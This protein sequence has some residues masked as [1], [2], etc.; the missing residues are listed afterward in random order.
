MIIFIDLDGTLTHT[1]DVKY[2]EL[3]DGLRDFNVSEIP[4]FQGSIDFISKLK[5]EGHRVIILS[6]SH[7]K[8]VRPIVEYYFKVEYLYLADKPN[9]AKTLSFIQS[10]IHLNNL[11]QTNKED[12]III[13][14]SVLDIQLGRKLK[15][16][17]SYLQ[18]YKEG[19]FSE[20]DGVGDY[21]SIIKY[22]PTFITKSYQELLSIVSN[23][24]GN[25]LSL[26]A[27]SIGVSTCKSVK[28]WDYKDREHQ[29]IVAFRC[30]ARQENGSCDKFSRADLYYQIDNP[31]RREE[32]LKILATGVENYLQG[33]LQINS[34]KWDYFTYVSDKSSTTPPNKL[35]EIFD[36]ISTSIPKI[37]LFEWDEN[38]TSSLRSEKD[39]RARQSFIRSHL[40]IKNTDVSLERKNIIV[41]DDQLTTGATA[42]EIRKKLEYQNVGNILI[43]TLFYMSLLVLDDKVCPEC[44]KPLVIKTN[45]KKGTKFYSYQPPQFGGDGCGYIENID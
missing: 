15:I 11:Y 19:N 20:T 24:Q 33:L 23:K 9:T 2:K 38:M 5:N 12:F 27:A 7:P 6:D 1:A 34:Y 41:L 18:L 28:F 3:K 43:V 31:Q 32:D 45:R 29:R 42:F 39:Y 37:K 36:L 17:T 35:T 22:G 44:G 26:E 16:L 10:D 8:Y 13:G 40:C 30:L 25:L 21:R 14:D 4:L